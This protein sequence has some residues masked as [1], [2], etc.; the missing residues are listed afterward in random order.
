MRKMNKSIIPFMSVLRRSLWFLMVLII[1]LFLTGCT[2]LKTPEFNGT[3]LDAETGN[4]IVD[5]R[6]YAKWQRTMTSFG[7]P[8][9]GK[10]VKELR[11]R[12]GKD[13][14]FTI[15]SYSLVNAIPYPIGQGGSFYFI[16]YAL[17]YKNRIFGFFDEGSF[18]SNRTDE[19]GEMYRS[20]RFV[21]KLEEM[22]DPRTFRKDMGEVSQ[23]VAQDYINEE[24]KL[25]VK[26]FGDKRW[27]RVSQLN[28]AEAY[29]QLGDY[30]SAIRKMKEVIED[31]PGE[32][33]YCKEK[34]EEYK[35]KMK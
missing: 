20:G 22:K 29:A 17:G 15:P 7:G 10:V 16:V 28:L 8:T 27:D 11:L 30:A 33:K 2:T 9:G 21:L 25:F 4:P 13:G 18:S 32:E 31:Y 3:V 14:K 34:I 6:I 24:F 5:V 35:K 12:T 26:R 1:P 23:Y 19:V